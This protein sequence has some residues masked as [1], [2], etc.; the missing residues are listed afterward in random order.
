MTPHSRI[1]FLTRQLVWFALAEPK[2]I[3]L[4]KA[5]RAMSGSPRKRDSF[6]SPALISSRLIQRYLQ[7]PFTATRTA[8]CGSGLATLDW[9]ALEGASFECTPK[10]TG[11]RTTGCRQYCLVTTELSG[12]AIIA[13]DYPDLTDN[14]SPHIGKR[15]GC[16]I[17]VSGASPRTVTM[18]SGLEPGEADFIVS[19]GDILLSTQYPR[20]SQATLCY[21]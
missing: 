11:Y 19:A 10:P 16:R 18:T 15:S 5:C 7:G 9:R 3:V 1:P 13:A 4:T 2:H 12:W 20:G 21:R 8:T 6:R 17:L 14:A